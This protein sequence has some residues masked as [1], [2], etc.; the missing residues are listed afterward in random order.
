MYGEL[1]VWRDGRDLVFEHE[2]NRIAMRALDERTRLTY[3][4][5][6][7]LVG[8]AVISGEPAVIASAIRAALW[9]KAGAASA[10]PQYHPRTMIKR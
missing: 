10:P 4:R 9:P 2:G 8:D 1:K 5:D 7:K 6:G 3:W